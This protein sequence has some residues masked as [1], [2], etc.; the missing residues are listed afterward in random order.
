M[1]AAKRETWADPESIRAMFNDYQ[2]RNSPKAI[3]IARYN[4]MMAQFTTYSTN[5]GNGPVEPAI[6]R[7][8]DQ[9]LRF[10]ALQSGVT[11]TLWAANDRIFDDPIAEADAYNIR[12]AQQTRI[13]TAPKDNIVAARIAEAVAS[14]GTRPA[15]LQPPLPGGPTNYNYNGIPNRTPVAVAVA[16]QSPF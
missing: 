6:Q 3:Y 12:M 4:H 7:A 10:A 14:G 11:C 16:P 9:C 8:K 13:E 1:H 15:T 5:P 2:N